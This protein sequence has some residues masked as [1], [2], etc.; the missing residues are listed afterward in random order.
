MT[1]S[2][3]PSYPILEII[4]N[5]H[6]VAFIPM[7][8]L[9]NQKKLLG[10]KVDEVRWYNYTGETV[11]TDERERYSF[12]AEVCK[13]FC[14]DEVKNFVQSMYHPFPEFLFKAAWEGQNS[15]SAFD[16]CVLKLPNRLY[17]YIKFDT[18]K[19]KSLLKRGL[20]ALNRP[21]TFNDPWDCNYDKEVSDKFKNIGTFCCSE[22][23]SNILMYSHY[24]Y[25]HSGLCIEFDPKKIFML[26]QIYFSWFCSLSNFSALLDLKISA[27][28]EL[29]KDQLLSQVSSKFREGVEGHWRPVFY[30]QSLPNFEL[31][32]QLAVVATCKNSIWQ[33]EK[34][35]RL[36]AIKHG[37][38]EKSG[39]YEYNRKSITS[40][41]FGCNFDQKEIAFVKKWLSDV[42]EISYK[43]VC[44]PNGNFS[45]VYEDC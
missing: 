35:W 19:T 34:E 36:F 28:I 27:I 17:K 21:S 42:P 8:Q 1:H 16:F 23:A 39:L 3:C 22:D 33:Y 5:G 11:P 18:N 38:P 20:I 43:R 15:N 26:S 25:N 6:K 13:T 37:V 24:A 29:L 14:W 41:S 4:I 45:I 44:N 30:Y 10:K 7:M 40:I 12:A 2:I 32:S 31:E 9:V